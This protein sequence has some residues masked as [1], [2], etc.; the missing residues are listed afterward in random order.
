VRR[1]EAQRQDRPIRLVE[2]VRSFHLGG[3]EMQVV[4]LL[5]GLP[6]RCQLRVAVTH[7]AGPLLEQ[8][9]QLG[10]LCEQFSLKGTVAQTNTL[11]QIARMARWLRRERAQLIHAHDFYTTLLAVPAARLARVPV[12][13][14]RLDLAHFHTPAQRQALAACTRAANHVIANA[15]A[16]RQ[17]LIH[18]EGIAP[19]RISLIHNGLDLPRFDLRARQPLQGPLPGADGAPV[20]V[21]VANM[22]HPV[23]RQ[24]DLIKAVAQLAKQGRAL[25]AWLVGDGV[26]RPALE[27]LAGKLGVSARVH[28]LGHRVDVPALLSRASLGVLCSSSE[29]LSN[30][31]IEGMAAGLPMVVTRVGGNPDL[32]V[33]GERGWVVEPFAPVQ[34]AEAFEKILADPDHGRFMGRQARAFVEKELTLG[35]LCA[36]HDELYARVAR[37][38]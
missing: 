10:Y 13:V 32:I 14:G 6:R 15:E 2:F 22:A 1:L 35:Q 19:E 31:V 30:A 27:A 8:V 36:R 16:I 33:D 25:Q 9:W 11:V 28:F 7:D 34:L 26:R 20:V 38:D 3:T 5:R 21:H 29:G 37:E 4:E 23:K 18:E 12:I 17:M 24:E